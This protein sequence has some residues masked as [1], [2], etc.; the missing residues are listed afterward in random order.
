ML[1]RVTIAERSY[2]YV[3]VEADTPQQAVEKASVEYDK[4]NTSWGSIDVD[5]RARP[6]EV[7]K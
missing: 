6:D 3:E 4:G 5:Y 7:S 2:G 1:Y